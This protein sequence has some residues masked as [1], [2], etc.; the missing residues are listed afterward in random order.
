MEFSLFYF[1]N[2][3]SDN[4][5]AGRYDLLLDGAR[6]A[7]EHGFAAVWTPERHFHPFGGVYPN[8][9]VTGAAVAAVTRR[10]GVRA[11]SVVGPLQS[12]LRVAEEW[13]VVDNLSG[14]RAGISFA[15]GW[16][17]GDFA[18]RPEAYPERKR[19]LG[20][21][22]EQVR[23]LWR[24]EA[25]ALTDGLGRPVQVRTYPPP[26]RRDPPIWLTSSGSP[27]T[28]R[29]AGELR[30]GVLTHLL[31]QDLDTLAAKIAVYR[32]SVAA[33]GWRGHVALMLH[34][35][36][37]HDPDEVRETVRE[38]LLRYLR[39]S[40]ELSTGTIRTSSTAPADDADADFIVRR[41]FER[42]YQREG[43]FGTV[44]HARQA[45]EVLRRA[46]VDEIACLI[47]FGVPAKTVLSS[48]E[49]LDEVR[50][51]HVDRRMS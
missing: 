4:A 27:E 49:L 48:L 21:T 25:L 46:G 17:P 39:T 40:L 2:D 45:V 47:D 51:A 42:F 18:L 41:S 16:H 24:G 34:T 20:E 3:V 22:V 15:S 9:A 30:C 12:P 43:L 10:V 1:A 31:G 50:A 23:R 14:G 19:L 29:T 5:G 37:G 38:P 7:D 11:G 13:A 6:F 44:A 32:E 26:V 36:L 35:F 33:H 28:F 8:P